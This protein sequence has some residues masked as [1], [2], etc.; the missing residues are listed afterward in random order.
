MTG[1]DVP[2]FDA[3]D[4]NWAPLVRFVRA[5]PSVSVDD[6]MWMGAVNL[7]AGGQIDMYKHIDTRR[8]LYLDAAGHAHWS[9]TRHSCAMH[10]TPADAITH[11]DLEVTRGRSNLAHRTIA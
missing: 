9:A 11:L 4:V 5:C 3:F 2:E 6:F 8:Y 10:R 7:D 1:R